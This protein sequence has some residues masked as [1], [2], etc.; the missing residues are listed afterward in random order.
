MTSNNFFSRFHQ[1]RGE[2]GKVINHTTCVLKFSLQ[3]SATP[4]VAVAAAAAVAVAVA[5]RL[6]DDYCH[7]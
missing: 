4:V 5:L 3:S 1:C 6:D 2:C 7:Y